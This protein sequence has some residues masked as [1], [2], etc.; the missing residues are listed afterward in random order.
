MSR[1]LPIASALSRSRDRLRRFR[2]SADL[3]VG[4]IRSRAWFRRAIR[5][6][7]RIEGRTYSV[8]AVSKRRLNEIR[9]PPTCPRISAAHWHRRRE[10][11]GPTDCCPLCLGNII[12]NVSTKRIHGQSSSILPRLVS[13][14]AGTHPQLCL[15]GVDAICPVN[16]CASE[17]SPGLRIREGRKEPCVAG[18]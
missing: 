5:G 8:G 13:F 15:S 4:I 11:S 7:K 18:A 6:D 16:G 17:N 12:Y 1:R 2:C 10:R 14:D 3:H 9:V